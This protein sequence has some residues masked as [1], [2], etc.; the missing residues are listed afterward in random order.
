[1]KNIFKV[2]IL[3]FLLALASCTNDKEPIANAKGFELRTDSSVVAPSILLPQDDATTFAKLDWDESNYTVESV[4]TYT[5]IISDHDN[6]P[7]YTNA[8][9][10]NGAGLSITPVSRKCSLTVKEI[11]DKLNLLPTF[12]CGAMNID[13]RVKSKLGISSNAYF[14]YSNPITVAVTGYSTALPILA[15]ARD[16]DLPVSAS[17]IAASDFKTFSDYQ[18]YMFLEP[19]SYRF[20]KPDPCGDFVAATVYGISGGGN[21][22]SMVQDGTTGY[23]VSTAGFY[24]VKANIIAGTYAI[25]PFTNFGI[26]GTA[27]G[28]STFLNA[29]MT[30]DAADK[31]F[32]ITFDLLKAKK[33]KFRLMNG[34]LSAAPQ[35][36]LGGSPTA[37]V[38]NGTDITVPGAVTDVPN[39]QKY[40][41]VLDVN[42]PRHYTY[43]IKLNPN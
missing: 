39:S 15:I 28:L 36:I 27:T 32:K 7:N 40:D 42:N 11:N 8:V 14:Q 34:T 26:F 43:T 3:S 25:T 41:I 33:F 9:E 6:D 4:S 29:P 1:M 5:I 21:T 24:L 23:V 31:K 35:N 19:G 37:C 38:E 20:Y 22:G 10:Y 13:I 17:K 16:A 12:R 2:S 18:G 30:Y